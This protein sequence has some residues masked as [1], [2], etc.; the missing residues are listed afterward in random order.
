MDRKNDAS[1]PGSEK[2][3]GSPP[4]H[5]HRLWLLAAIPAGLLLLAVIVVFV[6]SP[7]RPSQTAEVIGKL[8]APGKGAG[9]TEDAAVGEDVAADLSDVHPVQNV[10][11]FALT[12]GQHL[13]V[14]LMPAYC[15][16]VL[17]IGPDT[18]GNYDTMMIVSLNPV[19]RDIRYFSLP[20]DIYVD[21]SEEA[22]RRI[23]EVLP[24][25]ASD[26]PIFKIN[27]AHYLGRKIGYRE[28]EGRFGDPELDF[29]ADLL[30]EIFGIQIDDYVIARHDAFRQIV[31]YFGGVTVDVPYRMKYRDPVQDLDIDLQPG[32]QRLDGA[33]AEGFFRFREGYDE[34]GKFTNYG[35]IERK[36]HQTEFFKAFAEQ[37]LTLANV[38]RM[39]GVI[40]DI[41][42]YITTSIESS[43]AIAWYIR[44][45]GDYAGK[46]FTQSSGEMPCTD[47]KANGIYFL[48]LT[49]ATPPD[50]TILGENRDQGDPDASPAS[51]DAGS[52]TTSAGV[53]L[54][55][56]TDAPSTTGSAME[57]A[58]NPS[59]S[60]S[61][62]A[63]QPSI[64][65]D[66]TGSGITQSGK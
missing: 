43:D 32:V 15:R 33:N 9:T 16:N 6:I 36:K 17:L 24:H 38:G 37:H 13:E 45:G 34:N 22:K 31:D 2:D 55:G 65:P 42:Q 40:H 35:D 20:R 4:P 52:A 26:T 29:M 39:A 41:H 56:V 7:F 1:D 3:P 27:A 66:T 61:E 64:A 23:L 28:G 49:T 30:Q 44:L 57:G 14:P 54:D 11:P 5:K 53:A 21:Y 58:P 60:P 48:E 51:P 62:S 50:K 59:I 63:V 8:I 12:N 19:T 18:Y 47:F 46:G 10:I 25:F